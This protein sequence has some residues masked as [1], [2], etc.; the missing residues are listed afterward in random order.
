[1]SGRKQHYIPQCLLRGF[2]AGRSGKHVQVLVFRSGCKPY[3][4]STEGVA[5]ERDFYSGLSADDRKTLDDQITDYE[6]RLSPLLAR[7]RVSAHGEP[8][9]S[10]L[11]AEVAAHLT[12]R[13]AF[14]RELFGL[15]LKEMIAGATA[16]FSNEASV[17]SWTG[18]DRLEPE[19]V[20]GEEIDKVV[21]QLRP[22]L[23]VALP[24]AVLRRL[25][26]VHLRVGFGSMYSQQSSQ[27]AVMLNKLAETEPSLIRGSHSKVLEENL[28]PEGRAETLARLHWT[29]LTVPDSSLI[30]PD[31]V[32][33]SIGEH[34]ESPYRPYLLDS[35]DELEQILLPLS[36]SCLLVGCRDIGRPVAIDQFNRSAA[37]C[38]LEFFVSS[39]ATDEIAAFAALIGDHPRTSILSVVREAVGALGAPAESQHNRVDP[40]PT[41]LAISGDEIGNASNTAE[42]ARYTVS[43]LDCADQETAERI[44]AIVGLVF[45]ALAREI[46]LNRVESITFAQDYAGALQS[47]DRGFGATIPLLPTE[48]DYGAGVAMAPLVLRDGKIRC[49]IVMRSWLGHALLQQDDGDALQTGLHTLGSML[50]RVAFVD[51]VDTALPGVLLKP[52]EDGWNTLLF[53]HIDGACSAYFSA[54]TAAD[55]FPGAGNSYCEVFLAVLERAKEDI[56]NTRLAYRLHGDLGV[57]LQVATQAIGHVLVHAAALIGHYDGLGLPFLDADTRIAGALDG[58]G[59]SLWVG[60]YQR[61]LDALFERRGQWRSLNEFMALSVHMERLLWQFGVFP[62]RT[63]TGEVRVEI[64]LATDLPALERLYSATKPSQS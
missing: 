42:S 28:V 14:L 25:L 33:L 8:V 52:M 19:P 23:P 64:P 18:I 15:G 1:M 45:N 22:L 50:A 7:L 11:A 10:T 12:I 31:C 35:N 62:W 56:P 46:S 20:L 16:F 17:R 39:K 5:S 51:L 38:S 57:F 44:A 9:D 60:V 43:F 24:A 58:S 54:R 34:Q 49:C 63:E 41:N 30:L 21:E 13:G 2:E 53:E 40:L 36:S 29:V 27:L 32:A 61:D 47:I 37:A 48:E 55:L 6:Q 59:L 4:S 3:L 26:L